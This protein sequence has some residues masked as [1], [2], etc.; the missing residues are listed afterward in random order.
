MQI[1]LSEILGTFDNPDISPKELLL[2][3]LHQGP[4]TYTF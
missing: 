4:E 2:L 3:K 1:S